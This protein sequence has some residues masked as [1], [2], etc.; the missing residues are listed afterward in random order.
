MNKN[1][2]PYYEKVA[3]LYHA[4]GIPFQQDNQFSMDDLLELHQEIPYKSEVF[5]T[6]YYSFIFVKSGKGN[7]TTDNQTFKY[8]SKT[9]YFTNP[10]HLKAFEFDELEEGYLITFSE[11][12]L[13]KN[14]HHNIFDTFPYLL[15]ETVPPQKPDADSFQEIE[16]IYLQIFREYK[17]DSTYKNGIIG[18]LLTALLLKIKALFWH[19]YQPLKEGSEQSVIVKQFKEDLEEN[20]KHVLEAGAEHLLQAQD[21]ARKQNLNA[22][23]FSQ[24]IKSKTGK[25]PSQWIAEK[26]ISLAK[27]LLKH[28]QQSIKEIAY[29][30]GFAE[31]AHFS[32]FFKKHTQVSPSQY[33]KQTK[34]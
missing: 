18:S 21:Y 25:S 31:T 12:F 27:T 20:F 4:I 1:D 7:Y 28:S 8:D 11:E 13:R 22:S 32:N 3:D 5:R 29:T 2:I 10:G 26:T 6:N 23:Y 33:R 24:V 15:S 14:T 19:N 30:L 34:N 9:I 17:S 16:A